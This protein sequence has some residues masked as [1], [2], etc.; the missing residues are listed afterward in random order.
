MKKAAKIINV[1]MPLIIVAMAAFVVLPILAIYGH[2]SK[3][4]A[5]IVGAFAGGWIA[6]SLVEYVTMRAAGGPSVK[7]WK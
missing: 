2:D 6:G 5:K 1:L 4:A 7:E 3:V